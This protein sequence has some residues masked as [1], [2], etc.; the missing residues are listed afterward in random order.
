MKSVIKNKEKC[1]Q[2]EGKRSETAESEAKPQE[3]VSE[4][5]EDESATGKKK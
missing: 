2:N 3:T 1:D 5:A 4:E